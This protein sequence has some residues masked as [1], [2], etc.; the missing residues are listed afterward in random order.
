M[1]IRDARAEDASALGAL[2]NWYIAHSIATFD[3]SPMT[4]DAVCAWQAGFSQGP[5]RLL[6][7]EHEGRLLGYCCSHGARAVLHT[8]SDLHDRGR[9]HLRMTR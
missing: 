3:E 9:H 6:V 7:A 2:R 8:R 5:Y 4:F 1:D